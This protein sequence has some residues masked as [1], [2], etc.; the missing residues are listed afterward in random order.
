MILTASQKRLAN[1]FPLSFFKNTSLDEVSICSSSRP[2]G[3]SEHLEQQSVE[4][5]EVMK[6]PLFLEGLG[7]HT[8]NSAD[9]RERND[10]TCRLQWAERSTDQNCCSVSSLVS[11]IPEKPTAIFSFAAIIL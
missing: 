8:A 3:D 1:I 5:D 7:G 11:F 10:S 9:G 4:G 2:L 6:M